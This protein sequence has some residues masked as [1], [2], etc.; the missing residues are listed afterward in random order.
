MMVPRSCRKKV[1][2]IVNGAMTSAAP[3]AKPIMIRTVISLSIRGRSTSPCSA[4]RVEGEGDDVDWPTSI[5]NGRGTFLTQN[6]LKHLPKEGRRI[7]NIVL[8]ERL[9]LCRQYMQG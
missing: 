7:V 9:Q 6:V 4:G 5:L 2:E 8:R 3:A 1:S